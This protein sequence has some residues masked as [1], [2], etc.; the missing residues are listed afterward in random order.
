MGISGGG[1]RVGLGISDR[2]YVM[3]RILA[4]MGKIWPRSGH[5]LCDFGKD[6]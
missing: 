4:L 3:G 1:I 2:C 6:I 5:L